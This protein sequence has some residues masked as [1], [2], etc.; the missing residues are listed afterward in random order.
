MVLIASV[1]ALQRPSTT[2]WNITLP[3]FSPGNVAS[4][5]LMIHNWN[6]DW[7]YA[8]DPPLWTIAIEFQIYFLFALLLLPVWK[9]FG[10][11]A[12]LAVAGA[13]TVVP[14]AAGRGFA[15]PW[16]VVLFVFGMIVASTIAAGRTPRPTR[17]RFAAAASILAVPAVVA[18]TSRL[19][20]INLAVCLQHLTV[21]IAA[22]TGLVL[23][24]DG[25][26]SGMVVAGA[27]S[28]LSLPRLRFL[29]KISFS[30]Y[31][32]H[33]PLVA[34]V[35]ITVLRPM[36]LNVAATFAALLAIVVPLSVG[37]AIGFHALVERRF[38]NHRATDARA[39]RI[40]PAVSGTHQ[41]A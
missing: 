5:F 10:C 6:R 35:T 40:R 7:E 8:F 29:G 14:W 31:L 11:V 36:H 37:A 38:V 30:L 13:L 16:L 1:Q 20:S 34:V 26:N 25:G 32:V 41:V 15:R 39:S 12:T 27:R 19:S 18:L 33:Y 9:R 17:W 21:G 2:P 3:S 28:F 4:H 22:A 24:A 23:L